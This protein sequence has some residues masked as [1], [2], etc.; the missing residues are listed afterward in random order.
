MKLATR[1]YVVTLI[2]LTLVFAVSAQKSEKEPRNTAPSVGTGGS[3]GGPTG[4]FT[5]Y[6]SSTL[7]KGEYT[8]SGA[9][10]NYDRDPGNVDFSSVPLSFQVGLTNRLE[11]FFTTEA[12]RG[13]KVNA[14]QNL[15]SFYL[16]NSQLRVNNVLRRPGAIVLEPGTGSRAIYRPI[17]S[18]FT[19]YPFTG[20]TFY[21]PNLGTLINT[22]GPPRA[23]GA[24]DLFP[25][26]GSVYGSILPGVVLTTAIIPANQGGNGVNTTPVSFSTA[27]TYVAGAPFINRTWGTSSFNT[28]DFGFKW[29]F[30]STNDAWGHGVTAFYRYY[31]DN[32]DDFSGFNMMQRGSGRGS[33]KG[34]IGL[35]Y[36]IDARATKWANV[37]FN[38]GY[39]YTSKVEGNFG[40]TNAVMF[41]PG[42][43]LNLSVG[44]DFPVNKFFQPILEF[45]SLHYVGGRTFNALEQNPADGIAGFRVFPR[46]WFGFGF[47]YRHNFNQQDISSFEDDSTSNS[48]TILCGPVALPGCVPTTTTV[49][50]TGIPAGLGPSTDPHGYIAQFWIGRRDKRAGEVVNQP[51]NV[52]SVTLSGTTITLPCPPGTS[53]PSGACA[54]GSKTISVATRASDPENDVLTYNYTVSGG[55]IVGTGAN[56]QWDLSSAQVGTYTIVTGVDDGCGVCGR[57]DTKTITI[58]ECPDCVRPPDRVECNCGTVTVNGPGG[59]TAPGQTMNFTATATG[60]GSSNFTY[61]WTVSAGTIVSGQGTPSITVSTTAD[62]AGTNVTATVN[63]GGT[64]AG[65]N[66]PTEASDIGGVKDRDKAIPVDEYGPS[67]DDDVKAR[68]DNFFIQLNNNPGARGYVIIY[69][70]PAQIRRQKAQIMRAIN[71]PGSGHDASRITFVDGPAGEQKVKLWL[72]PAGADNPP[73]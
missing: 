52:D 51:A 71:R 63:V 40:G 42:D 34:D 26:V 29:R 43:E 54:D 9:L 50:T 37:S 35:T 18:A 23:G 21:T 64:Q 58:R 25:G 45:R 8:L 12:W 38:A 32:A 7:R 44:V 65:C 66:C 15:S 46:R 62:M 13:V 11:L 6:D 22:L 30:N 16:P 73:A 72:V 53:S 19:Q 49:T 5:V 2:I 57:T 56:V 59:T 20:G 36:F 17:G 3:V 14:P 39:L 33:N 47:A 31:W 41:D 70:T 68:I 67:Q 55:R 24:A 28:M 60:Q 69:G 48:V 61:N 4:L 10:S 1:V 27:P